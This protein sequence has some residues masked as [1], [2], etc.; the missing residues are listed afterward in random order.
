MLPSPHRRCLGEM[1]VLEHVGRLQVLVIDR[2]VGSHQGQRRLVVKVLSLAAH[3]L[4][5]FGQAV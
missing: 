4:M 3:L 2:I 5:R 1:V